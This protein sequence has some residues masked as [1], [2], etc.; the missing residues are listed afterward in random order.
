MGKGGTRIYCPTCVKF[1]VCKSVSLSTIGKRVHRQWTRNDFKDI[2]WF[3]RARLCTECET[4]F[5]TVEISESLLDELVESRSKR[6]EL[7]RKKTAEL[8]RSY[9]W[10]VAERIPLRLAKGFVSA[11]S[12]WHSHSSGSPVRA[13]KNASRV[14]ESNHGWV[15][16][17]GANTF[18]VEKAIMRCRKKIC[19]TLDA[20][21]EGI[22]PSI[23]QLLSELR[24]TI[25]GAVANRGGYEYE[26]F[27]PVE[28][29]DMMFGTHSIDVNDGSNF[30][31]RESGIRKLIEA[32]R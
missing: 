11:S 20:A 12:W 26:G 25:S 27:Y 6:R 29:G 13:R 3:R 14:Y 23:E 31:I 9:D 5:S 21:D 7:L 32:A 18:L 17:F 19:K 8:K 24:M 30:L 15:I 16:D 10:L 22:V 28:H 1:T 2:A 4:R